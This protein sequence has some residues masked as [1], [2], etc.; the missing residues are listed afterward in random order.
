MSPAITDLCYLSATE[1]AA[2]IRAKKVSSREA[3]DALLERVERHD[4][5][6]NLVVTLDPERA[7]RDAAAADDE[8]ARGEWRGPLHGVPM[9]IKDSFQ[10]A[11]LRTTSGAPDLAHHIPGE[12]AVPVARLRAAGAVVFGKTNLPL[13]AGDVQSYN[14]VFGQSNNPWDPSRTP[15]GSSG[16][17]AGALAAG[18]TPLELGSDIGGSIRNPSHSCGVVGHKPSYRL[19]PAQGQ[20]PGPPGTLTQ[21]DIAVAGP[22]A[23][24][25][26]DLELGLDVLAGPDEWESVGWSLAL[27]PARHDRL[28]D[29][30]I[31]AWID[32]ELCPLSRQV[33]A[34]LA[35]AVDA[36]E[37]A[38]ATVA[39]DAR[40]D[41]TLAYAS[42]VF[43]QLLGAAECGGFT[44]DEI[45]SMA[46]RVL[47]GSHDPG[48]EHSVLRHRAWL[49]AN[50]RRLQM[51]KKWFHFFKE[52]D[53][54][55][56]PVSPVPAIP[57]D[58]SEPMS[59]RT[60]QVDGEPRPYGDLIKWMGVTGVAYLPATVVPVGLTPEGLPVGIQI[61]GP[62]LEDRTT[63]AIARHLERLL[64]GF[65]PPPGLAS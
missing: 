20:I 52:W 21:A 50:E 23:R 64:G 17:A 35:G 30:R 27:R 12:D 1:L 34:L 43:D 2:A 47:T 24:T 13:Y 54:V 7:R 29:F 57:H 51:R 9:T 19:V 48:M 33:S 40:P 39:R 3:L 28:E 4:R 26:E 49:S 31:A 18:L 25:V 46:Q 11:G 44:Y 60:I 15:G 45:E 53:A 14:A 10:T 38:G 55:L 8:L 36:L 22:M 16:G 42:R 58:H 61:A 5:D 62:Y 65:R 32:D 6:L 56:L 41:F 59:R 63:L 37:R